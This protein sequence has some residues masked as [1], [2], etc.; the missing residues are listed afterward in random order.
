MKKTHL[1]ILIFFL[2]GSSQVAHAQ[3]IITVTLFGE[4][5][6]DAYI[7]STVFEPVST[8]PSLIASSWTYFGWEGNGR[9]LIKFNLSEIPSDANILFAE[10]SLYHDSTSSH[11]GHSNLG[12]DNTGVLMRIVEDWEDHE[13]FWYNL[14]RTTNTNRIRIHPP[15]YEDDNY[16]DINV[17]DMI[18]DMVNH[19]ETSQGFMLKLDEE[20]EMYRSLV[21]ASNEN[22]D[23]TLRPSL[24]VSYT[25]EPAFDSIVRLKP[26]AIKGKDAYLNSVY[27]EPDGERASLI[28]AVWNYWQGYGI[29]RSV[30]DFDLSILGSTLEV[31]YA[32]L[33]LFKN[34]SSR[35]AGHT[36]MGGEN[37]TYISRIIEP[38][39]E[40]TVSWY[41]QPETT[42]E[43]RVEMNT[44]DLSD[45]DFLSI[46]VTRLILDMIKNPDEGHGLQLRL[47]NEEDP[48]RSV[49]FSSSDN[50]DSTRWPQ[51]DLYCYLITTDGTVPA[52]FDFSVHPNPGKGLFK[53]VLENNCHPV[54]LG[55]Y[56][57]LGKILFKEEVS[58]EKTSVDLRGLPNGLYYVQIICDGEVRTKK[59][60]IQ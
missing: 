53:V 24:L 28:A 44:S 46:D 6:E 54:Q 35:H 58:E 26:G 31:E 11:T 27:A 2:F 1:Q 43:N 55:V 30:L 7:N 51:L 18:Q 12:G 3:D 5:V 41:F 16:P 60:L 13:V 21:F 48:Y 33:N 39:D 10:L 15:N 50:T 19:P 36:Q 25:N 37:S 38:W 57:S 22:Q 23:S 45:Q 47:Q 14:P 8:S 20:F 4:N 34:D 56:N 59:I 52:S 32:E 42:S 29:G 40:N 9:S 49:V 17:T